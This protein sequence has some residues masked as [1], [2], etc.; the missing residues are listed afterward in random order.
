MFVLIFFVTISQQ[1]ADSLIAICNS[2][3][4]DSIKIQSLIELGRVMLRQDLDSSQFYIDSAYNWALRIEY[5]KE[6]ANSLNFHGVIAWYRNDLVLAKDYFV[7]VYKY[8]KKW[9]LKQ[10]QAKAAGNIGLIHNSFGEYSNAEPYF[11]EAIEI[12]KNLNDSAAISKNSVDYSRSLSHRGLFKE[13]TA[14]LLDATSYFEATKN[15][16]NLVYAYSELGSLY[17]NQ[18]DFDQS[19]H[20][21]L[22]SEAIDQKLEATDIL[23]NIYVGIGLLY[24]QKKMDL[25]KAEEYYLKALN[26]TNAYNHESTLISVTNNLATLYY[27]QKKYPKALEQYK[28]AYK[29]SEGSSF[30]TSKIPLMINIGASYMHVHQFDSA[31]YFLDLSLESAT[32]AGEIQYMINAHK[33]LFSLD[34]T[35]GDYR[36]AIAHLNPIQAL[37]D[38]IWKQ[39][40]MEKINEL[41]IRFETEKKENEN[42]LLKKENELN[43]AIIRNHRIIGLISGIALIILIA[44]GIWL[45]LSRKKLAELNQILSE[46]K[47]ELQQLNNTKDKFFSI[48]AHDLKSPFSSLLGLLDSLGE[49][50]DTISDYEKKIIIDNLR[51]SSNNTF[52]LL[53]NLL[54][55]TSLQRGHIKFNPEEIYLTNSVQ[56][57]FEVLESR[58]KMKEQSL[59]M[60]IA[61][62]LVVNTDKVMLESTILNIVNNSIKFTPDGG[63]I[64]VLAKPL[65][66]HIKVS[67]TDNGIGI[68]SNKIDSLFSLDSG[69]KRK[70]TNNELGT[71]LGLV[72]CS[73]FIKAIGGEITVNSEEGVGSEFSFTIPISNGAT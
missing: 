17:A 48:I 73:D 24:E 33:N 28:L 43:E 70:G 54:E 5:Q 69:Y 2:E 44:L 20:Y 72:L 6:V 64:K 14:Y 41:K 52:N 11:L 9:N 67:I 40:N 1:K 27:M 47:N 23:A 56:H 45:Y 13:A 46:Q 29:L 25:E 71:G 32:Q 42:K 59:I 36:S 18:N 34:T 51:R 19:L 26:S 38:S 61:D 39:E 60:R 21:Y 8:S 10:F 63:Q 12:Y 49:D 58:A 62:N 30:Y 55:W 68:P 16:F 50:F 7:K 3:A 35:M 31:K 65:E 22:Q 15:E 4:E 53:I 57:V 66:T 37:H